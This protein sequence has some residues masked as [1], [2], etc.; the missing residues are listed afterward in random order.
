MEGEFIGGEFRTIYQEFTQKLQKEKHLSEQ[1]K[2]FL[3]EKKPEFYEMVESL[4][5][6][7][8]V[9]KEKLKNCSSKEEVQEIKDAYE[10]GLI[11]G[12][13][14]VESNPVLP[15]EKK[16]EYTMFK[17]TKLSVMEELIEEFVKS[18]R[19]G[20]LPDKAENEEQEDEEESMSEMEEL[21]LQ[22]IKRAKA[23]S[24]YA[25]NRRAADLKET[26]PFDTKG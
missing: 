13:S 4:E 7:I 25:D 6:E 9:Y 12:F 17:N 14:L 26:S 18:A 1:E 16:L 2:A 22:K 24:S 20:E 11:L 21:E 23:M 8:E 15:L 3:K 19:Y 10:D 5:H